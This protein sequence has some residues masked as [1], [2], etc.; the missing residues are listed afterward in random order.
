MIHT[1]EQ[2]LNVASQIL[3]DNKVKHIDIGSPQAKIAF[4]H[5]ENAPLTDVWV[6]SYTYMVFQEEQAFIYLDDLDELKLIYILTKHGY[7]TYP[8]PKS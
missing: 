1:S 5:D 7:V 4:R 8:S 2:A 6:I 3:I